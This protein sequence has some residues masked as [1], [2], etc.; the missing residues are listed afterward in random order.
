MPQVRE[1]SSADRHALSLVASACGQTGALSMNDHRYA[2]HLAAHGRIV[3]A[4]VPVEGYAAALDREGSSYLTD[5]FVHPGARDIGNGRALLAAA[6]D[7][8]PERVTTSSQDPRALSGYARFGARPVWPLLYLRL[9]GAGVPS[10]PSAPVVETAYAEGDAGWRLGLDGLSTLSVLGGPATAAVTAVVRREGQ[11]LRVLRADTPDP[12]GL[13]VLVAELARRAGPQG[14]VTLTV[15][16]PHPALA[17]VLALGA[18]IEE[19][20][21]WCATPGSADLVDP[22]R[23]L[24]SPGLS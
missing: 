5:L 23:T 10:A 24:P 11:H 17:D 13:P 14:V 22:T 19:V 3:V 4:G 2:D 1:P 6:W 12:R 21:L 8:R 15:P 16:G 7:G 9:F 20:D 18:R